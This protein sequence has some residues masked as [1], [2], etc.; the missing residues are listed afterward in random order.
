MDRGQVLVT[1]L[2][3]NKLRASSLASVYGR[4]KLGRGTGPCPTANGSMNED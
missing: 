1:T 3:I 2:K 4:G